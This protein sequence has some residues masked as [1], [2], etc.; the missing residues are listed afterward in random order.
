MSDPNWRHLSGADRARLSEARLQAHYGVQWLAR[1]A[2]GYVP[3]RPDD[4]HTNLGWEDVIGG[5][6]THALPDGSR[7]GLRLA[8]LTLLLLGTGVSERQFCLDGRTDAEARDWL[9]HELGTA[10][11]DAC[12]LDDPAPYELPPHAVAQGMAYATGTIAAALREL[13]HWYANANGLLGQAHDR[14]AAR[15]LQAPPVRCWPHHFDLDTLVTFGS[16]EGART[17]GVGFSPGDEYYGEPYFY[18]SLYPE[19]AAAALPLLPPVGRWHTH[20][21][22]AAVATA[23][24]IVAA[25]DQQSETAA[26]LAGAIDYAGTTLG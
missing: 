8:D 18:V 22:T 21:F 1:V 13:A 9:A 20:E 10:G 3:A 17:M 26:F 16:G 5:F 25:K 7:L 19:P 6:A 4:S 11:F 23:N 15:G 14:L 24:G 12:A 2:R